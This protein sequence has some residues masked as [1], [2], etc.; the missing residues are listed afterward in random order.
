MISTIEN[1]QTRVVEI[2]N[3]FFP[4]I[5]HDS[6]MAKENFNQILQFKDSF[7]VL[8]QRVDNLESLVLRAKS[9]LN[10]LERQME[11]AEDELQIPEKSLSSSIL[12]SLNTFLKPQSSAPA[13]NL[14][15]GTYQPVEIFK[16][17]DY[18]EK[19]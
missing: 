2:E 19:E 15:H 18:F 17:S 16:T 7:D 8:C 3:V 14:S 9:D 12:K 1:I 6:E 5:R 13:T 11:I 4:T 10:E